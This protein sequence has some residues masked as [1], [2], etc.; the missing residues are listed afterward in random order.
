MYQLTK[1][2]AAVL[3]RRAVKGPKR[4]GWSTAFEIGTHFWRHQ[5]RY[6]FDMPD[7]RASREFFDTV[8]F[9]TPV[10]DRVTIEPEQDGAVSGR[11][12]STPRASHVMLYL[13]GGG[14]AYA[15]QAHDHLISNV[16]EAAG[17]KTFALDYRL[18]PEH[19]FPAQL[20]DAMAAWR[21]LLQRGHDPHTMIIG[22]DSAGGNLVL[23][24]LRALRKIG[25]PMP[26]AAVCISPWT[27]LAN[28]GA[29]MVANEAFDVVEKRMGVRWGEWL[30]NGRD[31]ADPDISPLAADF[32]GFPPLYIQAGGAE[33][34]LD[35]IRAYVEKGLR[36]GASIEFDVWEHMNHDFQSL[37]E[38]QAE[39]KE[40]LAKIGAFVA[41]VM[42]AQ[43]T[44]NSSGGPGGL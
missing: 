23:C 24:L 19:A 13:H 41:R 30:T 15:A 6:A 25:L 12:F 16:A 27:D 26:A 28:S 5:M 4:P 35:M 1:S 39:S 2:T 21:W 33:I 20:E 3:M 37:G 18:T 34:L 32:T 43:E 11:W 36:A 42:T 44:V 38:Q 29:S 10:L 17:T 7:I 40:A 9:H 14:Y 8:Q 31:P 22:G